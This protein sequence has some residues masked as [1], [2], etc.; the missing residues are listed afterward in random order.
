MQNLSESKK[1]YIHPSSLVN[2]KK[3][4]PNTKVWA[5]CNILKGA[6]IGKNC[7]IN[8]HV[9][10]ENDVVVG[11]NVT[12]K[13]GVQLWDGLRVEDD[14]FVG[15]NATFTNDNFPR[16]KKYPNKFLV[17]TIKKGASIGA[18]ATIL[19]GITIGEK[20]MI[21][22][23][24]VVTKDVPRNAIVVGNPARIT[25][26]I[27][28]FD[29]KPKSVINPDVAIDTHQ[30]IK[31]KGVKL[32]KL[33]KYNDI[34]GDLSVAE[35]GKEI[36]FLVKRSFMVYNVPSEEIRGEHAH[37]K[38]DQFLIC[39]R[40]SINIV[41]DDGNVSSEVKMTPVSFGL[42]VPHKIWSIQ[43]KFSPDAMLLVYASGKYDSS[44]YIRN[45]DEFIKYLKK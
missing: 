26:Y 36:P 41:V 22:A 2:S 34:R 27:S 18:N 15:P 12:I 9:F 35:F 30:S 32:Y 25:G 39:L 42:Y 4:G 13:C 5:F 24:A 37:K 8:D 10:I 31:T 1:T 6:R 19:P 20:A 45:Y 43:Y 14:V 7:N 23:G 17:T 38:Q 16:S 33:P 44:E 3:I 11:D 28:A 29:V 40:G 21:G